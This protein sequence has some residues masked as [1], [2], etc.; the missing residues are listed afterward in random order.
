MLLDAASMYFR[1][2]Y[3]VPDSVRAPDG[4]PVNAVR[5]FL[6]A[7]ST[8]ITR[9][10]PT[11][12]VAVFDADW[13]PQFRVDLLPSYKAHRVAADGDEEVPDTLSPQVPVLCDVLDA[14]GIARTELAGYEADDVIG[15]LATLA[16]IPVDVVTGDRDL[17]QLVDDERGVRV[18]YTAKGF[19]KLEEV[20]DAVVLAKYGVPARLYADFAAL[21]G[22]PSDGLPGVPGVGEKSAAAVVNEVG[23]IENVVVAL[24][25]PQAPLPFRGKLARAREYLAVAPDVVRVQRRLDLPAVDDALPTPPGLP[26]DLERTASLAQRFGLTSSVERLV[27]ACASLGR[28]T[29]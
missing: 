28:A 7:V 26:R 22:D 10:S 23:S 6:D 16:T 27:T 20:D 29:G 11:H 19:G 12:L 21:R 2:Y 1:A 8:L 9:Y 4:M 3:G 13:R 5:G 17:F 25:D 15:T 24:D 18:L 14:I